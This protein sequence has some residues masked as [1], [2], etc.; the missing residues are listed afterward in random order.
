MLRLAV[1]LEGREPG[2]EPEPRDELAEVDDDA[3]VVI[4]RER[5]L[6]EDDVLAPVVRGNARERYRRGF[7][8]CRAARRTRSTSTRSSVGS[9]TSPSFAIAA[10]PRRLPVTAL[11]SARVPAIKGS[12]RSSD[13]TRRSR[14]GRAIA[15]VVQL[16]EARPERR[17]V[18]LDRALPDARL[19]GEAAVHRFLHG[20]REVARC[21]PVSTNSSRDGA[22]S[23]SRCGAPDCASRATSTSASPSRRSHSRISDARPLGECLRSRVAF[24]DGHMAS[25][26]S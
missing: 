22:R 25:S 19:A 17:H 7:A 11:V 18:D 15:T 1:G 4:R 8:R 26:G 2:R 12:M 23:A 6:D 10:R 13:A 24:H 3:G 9:A 20:M 5:V 21:R 14:G 16:E